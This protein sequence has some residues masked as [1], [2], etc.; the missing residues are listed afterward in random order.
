MTVSCEMFMDYAYESENKLPLSIRIQNG[1]TKIIEVIKKFILKIRSLKKEH[2]V[3]TKA[4]QGYRYLSKMCF[5]AISK[6]KKSLI[7]GSSIDVT[8]HEPYDL[9][10]YKDLFSE[11]VKKRTSPGDYVKIQTSEV[12]DMMNGALTALSSAKTGM[13]SV[14]TTE[15]PNVASV[16]SQIINYSKFMLKIS[17]RVLSFKNMYVEKRHLEVTK[18]NEA[19]VECISELDIAM[20]GIFSK[21]F[22]KNKRPDC[23]PEELNEMRQLEEDVKNKCVLHLKN[24]VKKHRFDQKYKN[25][26]CSYPSMNIC[27]HGDFISICDSEHPFINPEKF[28]EYIK[29]EYDKTGDEYQTAMV[30]E[31]ELDYTW[32]LE[33]IKEAARFCNRVYKLPDKYEILANEPDGDDSP[34]A[35]YVEINKRKKERIMKTMKTMKNTNT[36]IMGGGGNFNMTISCEMFMNY[37]YEEDVAMEGFVKSAAVT[38]GEIFR[39]L[40]VAIQRLLN[41]VR[42]FQVI[43]IPSELVPIYNNIML[44]TSII[45]KRVA[46]ASKNNEDIS[47][48]ENEY[49]EIIESPNYKKF[50]EFDGS[51]LTASNAKRLNSAVVVK[52]MN[53]D[54]NLMQK[55]RM[56]SNVKIA[57]NDKGFM[58]KGA[59]NASYVTFLQRVFSLRY[60]LYTKICKFSLSSTTDKGT[61]GNMDMFGRYAGRRNGKEFIAEINR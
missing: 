27:V 23:T 50:L 43:V 6:C 9:P 30:Y 29:D 4:L 45:A 53:T 47:Q 56:T 24:Y 21:L 37:I 49:K 14:N 12:I 13:R 60:K 28:P 39:T 61:V 34:S 40:I 15:N 22:K 2:V 51:N 38:V 31:K 59:G 41:N 54:L 36:S 44:R 32:A 1:I 16:F 48:Y 11:D 7:L 52:E 46:E 20:E 42:R 10:A 25:A 18:V 19:Y 58:G 57:N 35:M 55:C 8:F 3:P 33:L 17:N 5:D 26:I